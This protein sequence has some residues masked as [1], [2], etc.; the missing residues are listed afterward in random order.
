MSEKNEAK[1]TVDGKEI[2]VEA[3]VD[4][5]PTPEVV[6]GKLVEKKPRREGKLVKAIKKGGQKLRIW[7]TNHPV[8]A[9]ATVL[10]AV[11]AVYGGKALY[12]KG[13]DNGVKDGTAMVPAATDDCELSVLQELEAI[14]ETVEEPETIEETET[15]EIVG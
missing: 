13:Y 10:A 5:T 6:N 11:G 15:A 8:K 12:N 14:P 1:A 3:K 7:V 4:A 2:E 9:T